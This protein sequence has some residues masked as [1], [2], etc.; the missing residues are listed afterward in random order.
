MALPALD[1]TLLD[2][3]TVRERVSV[4]L[5]YRI[6]DNVLQQQ[7]GTKL[8]IVQGAAVILEQRFRK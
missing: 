1:L 6:C 3:R 8:M 2:I 5:S 7:E 4:V